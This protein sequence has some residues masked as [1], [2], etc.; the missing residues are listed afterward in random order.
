MREVH[1]ITIIKD[2]Y[3]GRHTGG[4]F[5]AFNRKSQYVDPDIGNS[6]EVWQAFIDTREI[7][8]VGDTPEEAEADLA[9]KV[10][11]F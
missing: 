4:K 11:I 8:G 2:N 5:L 10:V 9:S 7:Y 1:P 6:K 3:K